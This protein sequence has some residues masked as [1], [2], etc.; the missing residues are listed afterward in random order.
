[1]CN[2]N[3]GLLGELRPVSLAAQLCFLSD[4]LVNHVYSKCFRESMLFH[5]YLRYFAPVSSCPDHVLVLMEK[6]R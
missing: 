2:D 5:T 6:C 1:M 3:W 4:A